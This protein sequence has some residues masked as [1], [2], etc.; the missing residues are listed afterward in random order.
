MTEQEPGHI[1]CLDPK[2]TIATLRRAFSE[3]ARD[4][5]DLLLTLADV[6]EHLKKGLPPEELLPRLEEV[7]FRPEIRRNKEPGAPP[8]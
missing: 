8:S 7:A 3:V 6:H 1:E 2:D 4:R 5:N